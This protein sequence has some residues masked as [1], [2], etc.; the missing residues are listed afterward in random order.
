MA[1]RQ[2]KS[3]FGAGF[4]GLFRSLVW[5]LVTAGK[6]SRAGARDALIGRG[7]GRTLL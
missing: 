7:G 2:F 5:R 3:R 4:A 1:R 6:G